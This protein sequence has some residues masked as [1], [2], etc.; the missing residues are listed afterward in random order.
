MEVINF[1]SHLSPLPISSYVLFNF[2]KISLLFIFTLFFRISHLSQTTQQETGNLKGSCISQPLNSKRV[3]QLGSRWCSQMASLPKALS[4]CENR[5]RANICYIF[6]KT[7]APLL[8]FSTLPHQA[9]YQTEA[10]QKFN[11][12]KLK[13]LHF[14]DRV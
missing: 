14:A 3:G 7:Q 4:L 1:H 6:Q 11:H 2:T 9:P 10:N 12:W 5:V 8:D 13:H